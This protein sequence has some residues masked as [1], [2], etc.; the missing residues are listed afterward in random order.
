M[1]TL[2]QIQFIQRYAKKYQFDYI[3]DPGNNTFTLIRHSAD[4]NYSVKFNDSDI[5]LKHQAETCK[6][7]DV[8]MAITKNDTIFAAMGE[9]LGKINSAQE[10]TVVEANYEYHFM[11]RVKNALNDFLGRNKEL[12]V[13][14]PEEDGS[15]IRWTII[16]KIGH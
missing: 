7:L 11:N 4:Q 2:Q 9:I 14:Q 12:T 15:I 1:K 8:E 16:K 13:T 6:I 5:D 10:G 3:D